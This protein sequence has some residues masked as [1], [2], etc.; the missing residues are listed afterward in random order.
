MSIS[1]TSI[2]E[3]TLP[4][5]E[6]KYIPGSFP[7]SKIVDSWSATQLLRGC[8]NPNTFNYRESFV[9][10]YLNRANQVIGWETISI[11]GI[12][13]TCV[14]VRIILAIAVTS[15]AS[16]MILCHN[17]PSGQC[18]PSEADKLITNKIKDASTYFDITVLDH[19]I[20]TSESSFSF[21]D[22]GLL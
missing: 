13:Q 12:N 5:I 8:F 15:G 3:Y 16:A 1:N 21:A 17:H 7:K 20:L 2:Q 22:E 14:D 6:L 11:G 4:K 10:L 19:V 18:K 9:T